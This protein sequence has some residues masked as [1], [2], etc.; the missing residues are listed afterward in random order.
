MENSFF[1]EAPKFK[2]P[3]EELNYL[4]AHVAKREEELKSLG[5]TENALENATHDVVG[6]YKTVPTEQVVHESNILSNKEAQGI[7]LAL[8]PESHDTVMEELLGIVVTKGVRNA[9]DVAEK[10]NSPHINDD[11]HRILVQ[12]LK[13]DPIKLDSKEGTPLYRSVHMTLFEITLPPPIE[14]ADKSKGF[15][16]FIGAME[17]FYAG[18]NSISEGKNNEKENYFTL[19]VALSNQNDELVVYAG[20]PNKHVS[21]FEKQ[22]LAFYHNAKIREVADDY[23]VF[24]PSGD[25][26]GAYAELTQRGVLPIKTYDT[27]DHDPMN[28]IL[29][30]FSK[31][32]TT[33]EGAAIQLVVAPAGDK[34]IQDFHIILDDVK[35]GMSVKHAADNL[36]KFRR[37][38]L[39]VGK[40]LLFGHKQKVEGLSKEQTMK[41]RRAVDEG[42]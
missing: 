11:F 19:E 18:M 4:R 36:Y 31:L 42:A 1:N 22:I 30:V 40:D 35:A 6:E 38:F 26:V 41:G 10:M 20:I 16:E 12:Y 24:N 14:Q 17:Q 32:K 34:F 21:L 23:N 8:T 39:G 7:V 28:T 13:A 25:S 2:T 9:I 33:G 37:A 5:H 27:I 29:N 3:E 15:K